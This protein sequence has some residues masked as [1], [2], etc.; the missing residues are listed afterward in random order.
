METVFN[1]PLART[2]WHYPSR[3]H[4]ISNSKSSL[5]VREVSLK[6]SLWVFRCSQLEGHIEEIRE[7]LT[8]WYQMWKDHSLRKFWYGELKLSLF[9][10]EGLTR[11]V[12]FFTLLT[13]LW[14]MI[15]HYLW[16]VEG[17]AID[18]RIQNTLT[19]AALWCYPYNRFDTFHWDSLSLYVLHKSG[20]FHNLD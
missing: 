11:W 9:S 18:L 19:H 10:F 4:I 12:L 6:C 3:T 17:T 20:I 16:R 15:K 1:I 13:S 14:E 8:E 2:H 5:I 7:V